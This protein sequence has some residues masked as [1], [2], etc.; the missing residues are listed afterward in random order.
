M[1]ICAELDVLREVFMEKTDEESI[2]SCDPGDVHTLFCWSKYVQT[3]LSRT[4]GVIISNAF[5]LLYQQEM[6]QQGDQKS[7]CLFPFKLVSHTLRCTLRNKCTSQKR[8]P[9]FD[10]LSLTFFSRWTR[11][12]LLH[13]VSKRIDSPPLNTCCDIFQCIFGVRLKETV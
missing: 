9:L 2:C 11:N 1:L 7:V 3:E 12:Y 5:T 13:S 8:R 6:H 4:V 10:K